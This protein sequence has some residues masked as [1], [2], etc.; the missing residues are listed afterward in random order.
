MAQEQL[1]AMLKAQQ[2]QFYD[3]PAEGLYFRIG[4]KKRTSSLSYI[5]ENEKF[6]EDR[7]K[8]VRPDFL[9]DPNVTHWSKNI[10]VKNI[11]TYR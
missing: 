10:P 9:P 1:I 8:I 5:A 11:V 4:K 2:S 3:G 7:A 6:L